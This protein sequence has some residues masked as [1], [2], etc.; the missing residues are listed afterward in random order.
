MTRVIAVALLAAAVAAAPDAQRGRN[1]YLH[2]S[3]TAPIKAVV[4]ADEANPIPGTVVPCVNCHGYDGRGKKEG[5]IAPADLRWSTLT[6]AYAT[7]PRT[8]G[9][10]T[11][12]TLRRAFTMGFDPAGNALDVAMPHYQM[13]MRDAE[14]LVAYLQTL[15]TTTDPGVAA[16]TIRIGV[17][18]SPDREKA[19]AV[20]DVMQAYAAALPEIYGRRLDLRFL[21]LPVDAGARAAAVQAFL[22]KEQ[23]FALAGSSLLGAESA[24]ETTIEDSGTPSIAAF[25]ST[26]LPD[27]HYNFT[28]FGDVIDAI[29]RHDA[30]ARIFDGKDLGTTG[31]VYVPMTLATDAIFNAPPSVEVIVAAPTWSDDVE[32]EALAELRALSPGGTHSR[33]TQMA[34][35]ASVKLLVEAL[36]RAGHDVTREAVIETIESLYRF[37]TGLTPPLSFGPNRHAG[38]S[39][40]YLLHVD[41]EKKVLGEPV[42]VE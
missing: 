22:K 3:G 32:P 17:L 20:R 12:A 35:L 39:G 36:G 41:R 15:G 37:R 31:R 16:K 11:K 33:S 19:A 5:G 28:L 4:N 27:A 24:I 14:D 7:G 30:K 23:P 42:W 25:A 34:A 10:Y 2:G 18:L 6:R 38:T 26:V 8:H 29:R 40:A 21:D 1:I 13:S 9:P